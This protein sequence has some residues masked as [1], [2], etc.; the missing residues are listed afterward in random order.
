MFHNTH[1]HGVQVDKM[2]ETGIAMANISPTPM[3]NNLP[4]LVILF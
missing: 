4:V 1:L 2:V 3:G